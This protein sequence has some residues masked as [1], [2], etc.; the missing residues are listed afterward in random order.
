MPAPQQLGAHPA[1]GVTHG[2]DAFDVQRIGKCSDVVRTVLHAEPG[3]TKWDPVAMAAQARSHNAE[4]SAEPLENP[5]PA[6]L[7]GHRHAGEQDERLRI[8]RAGAL[9]H[10]RNASSWEVNPADP[11]RRRTG[12]RASH[13]L[14]LLY[15][16][17]SS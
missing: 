7:G 6:Q 8:R 12:W 14:P 16:P 1:D 9:P 2:A 3:A 4:L 15:S 17:I 10:R 11:G 13:Y 5:K